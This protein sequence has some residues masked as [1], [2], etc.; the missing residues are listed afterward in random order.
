MIPDA[1]HD[2]REARRR[3]QE[4][5]DL[6]EHDGKGFLAR[7]CRE[8]AKRSL[9][10]R[11]AA[12]RKVQCVGAEAAADSLGQPAELYRLGL[13]RGPEEDGS[14]VTDEV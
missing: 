10:R 2:A 5:R 7:D 13:L 14:L 8:I 4:V 1:L 6:V 11:Q 9:P 3:A 12:A